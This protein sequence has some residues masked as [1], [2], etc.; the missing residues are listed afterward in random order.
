M[1]NRINRAIGWLLKRIGSTILKGQSIMNISLP[2]FIFDKRSM[3]QV[4]AYVL[5]LAPLYFEK[6]FYTKDPLERLKCITTFFLTQL[7]IA[8]IQSKPFSPI[9]GETYQAKIG[10][11]NLYLEQT[12]SKPLTANI[13]GFDD[14]RRYKYSG[15]IQAT[16]STG[17]NSVKGIRTGN[18]QIEFSDG[19]LY[20]VYFPMV[21]V[22]GTTMGAKTF[23]YK[24][25]LAIADVYNNYCS[26]VT[27]NPDEKGFFSGFF[28]S[29]KTFPDMF[30]GQIVKYSDVKIDNNYP[31]HEVQK[32]AH[33]YCKISGHWTQNIC[34]D[35][36]EY[37]KQGQ[38]DLLPMMRMENTLLSDS[39]NR[40]DLRD[41]IKGDEENAQKNKEKLEEI[42]RGDRKLRE[43]Y[44]ANN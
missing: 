44:K 25:N 26:V 16:A 33:C 24:H 32:N 6:A 36:K 23:N 8:C 27:F 2:V 10:N 28:S 4:Y 42:Q 9:I 35:K 18:I 3:L 14:Q 11:F 19:T 21:I 22:R 37:W 39:W 15:Y 30:I 34:F 5:R 38:Y 13:Y 29:K 20:K 1:I 43:K 40:D 17:A 7:H 12:V 31:I 41:F